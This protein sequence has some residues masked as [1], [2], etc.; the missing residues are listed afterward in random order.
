MVRIAI[1]ILFVLFLPLIS[2]CQVKDSVSKQFTELKPVIG[3]KVTLVKSQ[4]LVTLKE[5]EVKG[6]G[7]KTTIQKQATDDVGIT[8]HQHYTK[9]ET[10]TEKV[11]VPDPM[12]K[13][14]P[15]IEIHVTR[16]PVEALTIMQFGK[17]RYT[18]ISTIDRDGNSEFTVKEEK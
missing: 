8:L 1:T 14:K 18:G 9:Y 6:M 17:A 11:E 13:E 2:L 7:G 5:V 4:S 15:T 16:Y 10:V 3:S 12:G